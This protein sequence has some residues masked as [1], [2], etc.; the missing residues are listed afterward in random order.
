[1]QDGFSNY[2]TNLRKNLRFVP[3]PIVMA[4]IRV[5]RVKMNAKERALDTRILHTRDPYA[6]F[7]ENCQNEC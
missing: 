3:R 2:G 1:M 7:T 6:V 4:R 5:S